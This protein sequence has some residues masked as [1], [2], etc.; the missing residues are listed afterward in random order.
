MLAVGGWIAL[1]LAAI[2]I[3]FPARIC[4]A[5]E[6][7]RAIVSSSTLSGAIKDALGR[8]IAGAEVRLDVGGRVISRTHTDPAGAFRFKTIAAG[9]YYFSVNK[10]GFKPTLQSLSS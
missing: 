8:P 6:S 7:N 4:A 3:F 10:Q 1:T 5:N 2:A 9:A